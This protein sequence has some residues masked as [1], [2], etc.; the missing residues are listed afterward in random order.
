M[1]TAIGV[2]VVV[3]MAAGIPLD[4]IAHRSVLSG[5]ASGV[6]L[7]LGFLVVGVVV[8]RRQ[9]RHPIG[10]ILLGIA[11][12]FPLNSVASIYSVLDYRDHRG[13][14]LGW[15]AVLVQPAWSP[16]IVLFGLAI[17]LF[18]DGRLPSPRWR[19]ALWAFLGVGALWLVGAFGIAADTVIRHR[20]QVTPA[21]DLTVID[22]TTGVAAWWGAVQNLFFVLLGLIL[23]AWI[24]YQ[25]PR[26]R[27]AAPERRQQLK[28]LLGGGAIAAGSAFLSFGLS[29]T[30]VGQAAL[31]GVVA[32]P[33]S[34]GVGILKYRLYDIDVIMRKTLVYAALIGS[35]A[36]LY[37]AGVYMIGRGLQALTGQSGALAVTLSTLAVAAAFQPLR[38][39][40]Q[41]G[42]DHRFY[43][44]KYDAARTL[45]VFSGRLRDQINLTALQSEVLDLVRV[46][47]QPAQVSLW[48]RPTSARAHEPEVDTQA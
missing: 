24:A 30:P 11:L 45:D 14:P 35:L 42:V 43:R 31:V 33:I 37:L 8:A 22:H 19:W 41:R 29:P 16:A 46:T 17:L 25:V 38:G 28:W 36:T 4:E 7:I 34:L 10:W 40:I 26:Y 48:L 9:P 6:P 47:L 27:R 18:P 12:A 2:V 21:G 15:V 13:L 23:L 20:I 32:L 39:R 3:L 1:A 5:A 44:Q